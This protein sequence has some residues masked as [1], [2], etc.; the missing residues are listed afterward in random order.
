[1][2]PFH[3]PLKGAMLLFSTIVLISCRSTSVFMPKSAYPPDPWVKGYSDPDDCIGGEKLAAIQFD[4]PSYP[5]SAFR[6]G[7][8]GWAIVRLN[9]AASGETENVRIE[10]SVPKGSFDKASSKAVEAWRF[11]PPQAP[12]LDCRILLRYRA[13]VVT[14]GN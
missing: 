14:L 10:R 6:N 11:R 12:L 5:K 4:L 8:Q 13:G 3:A 2:T 9:V 7:Q 1:M